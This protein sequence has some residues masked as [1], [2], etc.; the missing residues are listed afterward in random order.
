M[1]LKSRFFTPLAL[2][3]LS[4]SFSFSA[5]AQ[6]IPSNIEIISKMTLANNYF[7]KKWPNFE[8]N[9]L[10]EGKTQTSNY[11]TRATFIDGLLAFNE[12]KPNK[13]LIKYANDWGTFHKWNVSKSEM[14]REPQLMAAGKAYIKLFLIDKS[15]S[16]RIANIK[17]NIDQLLESHRVDDWIN[18][19]AMF[20]TM[21][22][23]AQ[24]GVIYNNE[25][26][27]D[28]LYQMFIYSKVVEGLYSDQEFLWYFN[29]SFKPP[30]KTP[31]GQNCF[32]SRGNGFVLAALTQV[33]DI[34]PPSAAHYD[35]YLDSY[36]EMMIAVLNLQRNDGFW[37]VSLTDPNHFGGKELTGTALI[38]Y[39]MAWGV[40]KG[41]IDETTFKPLIAKAMRGIL[42]E[43]VQIN[44]SLAWIQPNGKEPKDGQPLTLK[45][46]SGME[47]FGLGCFLLAAAEV[48]K[49]NNK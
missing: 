41:Q 38:T 30:F 32:W 17:A 4:I 49:L 27:L 40:R 48:V 11:W 31:K 20:M 35:E 19:E 14:T 8:K 33:L 47:D 22:I 43:S 24:L 26:Y 28:K 13:N 18:T 29:Q 21:P 16:N 44:G 1:S 42:N 15:Q 23:M 34:L 10:I 39:S 37:N 5:L 9:I 12:V 46:P 25:E 3:F 6:K 36:R 7:L 2:A 45:K